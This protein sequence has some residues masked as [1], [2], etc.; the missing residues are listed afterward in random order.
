MRPALLRLVLVVGLAGALLAG[1]GPKR[2]PHA[3]PSPPPT[4]D[5][6]GPLTLDYRG[7]D[8]RP[9][10]LEAARRPE[11][12]RQATLTLEAYE[13]DFAWRSPP[14]ELRTYP[15][16]AGGQAVPCG[17]PNGGGCAAPA[18]RTLWWTGRAE[19]LYHELQ[20]LR[21]FER[22]DPAWRDHA[23]PEWARVTAWRPTW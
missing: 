19:E 5:R 1:C 11:L 22:G 10:A 12:F 7:P 20:H 15:A 23:G 6:A 8:D 14:A 17:I 9:I 4:T 3:F 21:L 18:T 16:L 13:R 2:R